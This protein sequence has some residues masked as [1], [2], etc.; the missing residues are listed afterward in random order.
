MYGGQSEKSFTVNGEFPGVVTQAIQRT[1]D[2]GW[3]PDDVEAEV[4]SECSVTLAFRER[5]KQAVI[6]RQNTV[7]DLGVVDHFGGAE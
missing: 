6:A 4:N 5:L 1:V 2:M 3:R 7:L